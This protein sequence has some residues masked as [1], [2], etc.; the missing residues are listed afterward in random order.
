M[1][2][3]KYR[4]KLNDLTDITSKDGKTKLRTSKRMLLRPKFKDILLSECRA[5]CSVVTIAKPYSFPKNVD[6]EIT[7]GSVNHKYI[8]QEM[9]QQRDLCFFTTQTK[10]IE[11]LKDPSLVATH[12]LQTINTVTNKIHNLYFYDLNSHPKESIAQAAINFNNIGSP[13]WKAEVTPEWI[14][15][16]NSKC[17]INWLNE[18]G[19]Q[20][21]RDRH[22]TIALNLSTSF[23]IQYD[24]VRGSYTKSETS[25]SK[26]KIFK[27]FND[28][29]I[30]LRSKD[31]FTVFNG[32]LKKQIQSNIHIAANEDILTLTYSTNN[33]EYVIAIPT[34]SNR[35]KFNKSAFT[36]Y[37]ATDGN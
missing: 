34:C 9:I 14:N 28:L 19:S 16:I 12:R 4:N 25:I 35:S 6:K 7:L 3:E 10:Q 23:E 15:E 17:V 24:G 8:E 2:F 26:P 13:S 33:A 37:E 30:I 11:L 21:N 36:V 31:F 22:K 5:D 20:I 1:Q 18:F 29:S 32:M 27:P